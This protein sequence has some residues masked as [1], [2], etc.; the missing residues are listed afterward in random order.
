M[1][2]P[3]NPQES[4]EQ[5]GSSLENGQ[6]TEGGQRVGRGLGVHGIDQGGIAD[7]LFRLWWGILTKY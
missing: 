2:C 4:G 6:E 1:E 5:R 3:G 7:G